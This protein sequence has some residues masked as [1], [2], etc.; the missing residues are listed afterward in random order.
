MAN[1][2]TGF[3]TGV[4]KLSHTNAITKNML[5]GGVILT[6]NAAQSVALINQGGTW[7][8]SGESTATAAAPP[9]VFPRPLP[10]TKLSATAL[11]ADTHLLIYLM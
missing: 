4:V 11:A 10:A 3:S 5:V 2:S 9:F 6:G 8:W 7:I 1:V